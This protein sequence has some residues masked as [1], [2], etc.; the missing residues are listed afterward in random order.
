MVSLSF[1]LLLLAF[2]VLFLSAIKT[3]VSPRV[4]LTALG[5]ALWVLSLLVAGIGVR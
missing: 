1:I 5:L 2:I 4:D 3:P